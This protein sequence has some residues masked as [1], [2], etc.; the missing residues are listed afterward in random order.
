M[1]SERLRQKPSEARFFTGKELT[2]LQTLSPHRFAASLPFDYLFVHIAGAAWD[3]FYGL[4]DKNKSEAFL[5]ILKSEIWTNKNLIKGSVE[6]EIQVATAIAFLME[7]DG[8]KYKEH[9]EFIEFCKQNEI[10]VSKKQ[11]EK[12]AKK[13]RKNKN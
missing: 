13:I 7:N 1:S 10:I 9:K 3:S 5:N 12:I 2:F 4:D 8:I 11:V 6:P